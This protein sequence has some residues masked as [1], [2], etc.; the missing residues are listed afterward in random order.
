MN[1]KQL[2]PETLGSIYT[3]AWLLAGSRRRAEAVVADSICQLSG[4]GVHCDA[5]EKTLLHTVV[6]AA[7]AGPQCVE[8]DPAQPCE[9]RRVLGLPPRLRH[10]FALRFLHGAGRELCAWLLAL[11]LDQVDDA[12]AAAARA[13]A[14]APPCEIAA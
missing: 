1:Q 13:L 10:V 6:R 7:V 11:R 3:L 4:S 5:L 8:D 12:S 2:T 9:L 14:G